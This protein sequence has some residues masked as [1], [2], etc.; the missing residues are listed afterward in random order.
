MCIKYWLK[1]VLD[2]M[3][4]MRKWEAAMRA[5]FRGSGKDM[6]DIVFFQTESTVWAT[7]RL[8][9]FKI[10]WCV[11]V[12]RIVRLDKMEATCAWKWVLVAWLD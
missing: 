12:L 1:H 10:L 9:V 2:K 11:T 5:N 8:S 4:V 7:L 6:L 3:E